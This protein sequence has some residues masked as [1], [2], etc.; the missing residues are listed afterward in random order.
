MFVYVIRH[1][2][3]ETN[4]SHV[5]TGWR[6]VML[7][8]KGVQDAHKAGEYLNNVSF[9][10]V[11]SS[12]LTRA[13]RTAQIALPNYE[14]EQSKELR[15]INV[16]T[17][18]GQPHECLT[19]EERACASL[20][21]YAQYEGES[22]EDMNERIRTFMKKMEL[23]DYGKIAVFSHAGWLR[24]MLD[25]VTGIKQPRNIIHCDNC[26]ISIYEYKNSKWRLWSWINP[27]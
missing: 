27:M 6:D 21:G 12:D 24:G 22:K 10:K 15:E 25:I 17:L 1:G 23:L 18:S 14:I 26:A 11:F 3:S 8:D 7:T 4:V 2:Q 5:W 19:K 20:V 9:D 13:Y 16:G